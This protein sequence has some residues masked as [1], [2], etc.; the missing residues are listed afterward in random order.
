MLATYITLVNSKRKTRVKNCYNCGRF[1]RLDYYGPDKIVYFHCVCE[2]K[3]KE[4]K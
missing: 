2:T 1:R 3:N 4:G